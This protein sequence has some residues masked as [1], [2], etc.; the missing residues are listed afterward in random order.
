MSLLQSLR[1]LKLR[2]E[3]ETGGHQSRDPGAPRREQEAGVR[4]RSAFLP[5]RGEGS[6]GEG[7][8]GFSR[9]C[10]QTGPVSPTRGTVAVGRRPGVQI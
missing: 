3:M 1:E 9:T 2:A 7:G 6:P 10:S 5:P 8:P 4:N